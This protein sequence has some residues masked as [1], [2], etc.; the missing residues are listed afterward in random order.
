MQSLI[1]KTPQVTIATASRALVD[2]LLEMNTENRPKRDGGIGKLVKDIE[3]GKFFLTASGIGVSKEGVLLDGQNRLL[4]IKKS[5]YPPVKFVLA[6]GLEKESQRVVDRHSRR[7]LA[8]ALSMHMG[9]II[10]MQVVAMVNAVHAFS[11]TRQGNFGIVKASNLTDSDIEDFIV[12]YCDLAKEVVSS[13][14]GVRAPVQAAIFVYALH[15][16]EKA[17]E[18][19]RQVSKGIEISEDSPAFRLRESMERLKR[20]TDGPGRMELFKRT[21]NACINHSRGESVKSLRA[22]DSWNGAKWNWAIS[23]KDIFD[24]GGAA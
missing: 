9:K 7:N 20:A 3:A 24:Q 4:A 1:S 2:K 21:A 12:E 22:A 11:A 13:A 18:F 19:A 6:I 8:E 17:L 5:G 10:S 14:Q 15:H 23:G 16:K